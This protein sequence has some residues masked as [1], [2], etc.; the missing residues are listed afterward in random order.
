MHPGCM[1]EQILC[2]LRRQEY[3]LGNTAT[4]SGYFVSFQFSFSRIKVLDR[5]DYFYLRGIC[6]AVVSECVFWKMEEIDLMICNCDLVLLAPPMVLARSQKYV[7]R[8][9]V[10]FVPKNANI[11]ISQIQVLN[12]SKP[13][14]TLS[15]WGV[16][17]MLRCPFL[18]LL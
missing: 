9:V 3:M 7:W 14:N 2:H 15:P 12:P 18:Y 13:A 8:R 10:V 11:S 6:L 5:N 16:S 17:Q 1:L 4:P